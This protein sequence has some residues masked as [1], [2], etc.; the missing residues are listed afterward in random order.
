MNWNELKDFCN[1]LSETELKEKVILWRE[2]EAITDII[3]EQLQEDHYIKRENP[4]DGCFP[5]SECKDL[6]PETKI[7]RVHVKGYPVLHEVF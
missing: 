7:K 2:D 5:V 3:A 1:K 4:E 6:E